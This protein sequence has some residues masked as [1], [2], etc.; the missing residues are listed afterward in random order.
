MIFHNSGI[1]FWRQNPSK[2]NCK[3]TSKI[4]YLNSTHFSLKIRHKIPPRRSQDAHMTPQEGPRRSKTSPRRPFGSV[5]AA[6][7]AVLNRKR[8]QDGSKLAP[9]TEPKSVLGRPGGVLGASWGHLGSVLGRLGRVLGRFS[10]HVILE[11]ILHQELRGFSMQNSCLETRKIM[12]FYWKN[13]IF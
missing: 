1:D 7:G 11:A 10:R 4:A 12:K 8:S 3:L 9:K 2:T 5:L 6:S 13:N